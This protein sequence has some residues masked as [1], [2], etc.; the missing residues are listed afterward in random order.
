MRGCRGEDLPKAL[1]C[2]HKE[3]PMSE[4]YQD[5]DKALSKS[6]ALAAT[7]GDGGELADID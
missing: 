3:A 1:A 6:G 4:G 5:V 7:P 2:Y